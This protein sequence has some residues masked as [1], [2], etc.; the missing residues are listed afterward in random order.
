MRL[1]LGDRPRADA[2]ERRPRVE[3]A[4]GEV[5]GAADAAVG[6]GVPEGVAPG[7]SRSRA[8]APSSISST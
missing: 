1:E 8:P 2:V 4:E 3:P 6:E 5:D 7:A